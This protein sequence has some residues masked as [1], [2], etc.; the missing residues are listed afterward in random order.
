MD[1]KIILLAE[2][3]VFVSDIYYR[4]LTN[5]GFDVKLASNGLEA[6]EKLKKD[7]PD[8]ILLDVM[9]PYMNGKE[10][11]KELKAKDEWKNIPVIFLTNVSE[12]DDMEPEILEQADKYLIKSHFTPAEVVEKIKSL[13]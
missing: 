2:D 8:L 5:E 4:K 11:I 3:D 7:V 13:L 6:I 10:V 12:K 9:M 1:K